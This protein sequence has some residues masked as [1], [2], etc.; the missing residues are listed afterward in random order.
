[1]AVDGDTLVVGAQF[2]DSRGKDSG[3]AYVFERRAERWH[4]AAVL[5]AADAAAGDQFGLTVSVSGETIVVGA[6]LSDSRGKDAGAAYVFTRHDGR[7]Q[8]VKKLIASD[9]AAGDLFG[10]VSLDADALIVS[11][12]LNDDRGNNAGKAYFLERRGGAW[13]E[14]AKVTA[15]NGA[16]GDEFGISIALA[17]VPP[18]SGPL[19]TAP[20]VTTPGAAYVFERGDGKW[21]QMARVTPSDPARS[22]GLGFLSPRIHGAIVVGAPN[23]H[24]K[25]ERAGAAYV[26]ERRAGEWTQAARMTASD[27]V[28]GM[29]FGNAVAISGDTIVVGM[30]LNGE[31]KR[32]GSAYVFER[33][34]GEWSE[35]ARLGPEVTIP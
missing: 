24:G 35:T 28:P 6:R 2:A 19:A 1:M 17:A 14:T 30:L 29:W 9:A 34:G 31:G 12:D 8:Q 26:F 27:A 16:E 25:G 18:C 21:V 7:W 4:R 10:R 13:A 32:S 3:L 20:L 15:P 23:H 11:A 33:R 22:N 5:S